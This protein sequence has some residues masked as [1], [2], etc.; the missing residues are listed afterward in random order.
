MVEP[1]EAQEQR[2]SSINSAVSIEEMAAPLL[3]KINSDNTQQHQLKKL[4]LRGSE[5]KDEVADNFFNID[6]SKSQKNYSLA[7]HKNTRPLVFTGKPSSQKGEQA[8]KMLQGMNAF[9]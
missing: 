6:V 1:Q 9:S 2:E 8:L 3:T 4:D 7:P 5:V